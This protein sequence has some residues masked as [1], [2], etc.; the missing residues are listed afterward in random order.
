MLIPNM[1]CAGQSEMAMT[2]Y[3]LNNME[4]QVAN[5]TL[6]NASLIAS[7]SA[8]GSASFDIHNVER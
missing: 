4:N 7:L 8:L 6:D 3:D 5:A 2:R 1:I